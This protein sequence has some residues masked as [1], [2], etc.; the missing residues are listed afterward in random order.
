MGF[1]SI[2]TLALEEIRQKSRKRIYRTDPEAWLA[3][4]MG[5]RWWSK[6][7]E[8]AHD[9]VGTGNGQTFTLVKS[10]NGVGKTQLGADLMTW[11]V[12]AHDPLEVSVLATANVFTQISQNAFKYITDNYST[13]IDLGNPLP[14]R[15]VSDP[16]VRLDR[17]VGL[18][19]KD[20]IAGRRPADKNLLS[21]FQGTHDGFVMVLMDES[22]GLPEDLWIGAY[23]VTTNQHTAILA[24]GNPDE[25]GT[26]FHA[27]FTDVDRYSDWKRHTISHFDTPN[28][29]GEV[30]YPDDPE[31]ERKL[32]SLLPQVSTA[33]RLKRE[34]HPGVYRAKV[35]G[36]FPESSSSS[37]FPH[38]TIERAWNTEIVAADD[39][40]RILGVDLS[41]AGEDSTAFYLNQGG[42]IRRVNTYTKLDDDIEHA[43]R[44][45]DFA[46]RNGINRVQIDANGRGGGVYANLINPDLFPN[47]TYQLVGLLGGNSASDRTRWNNQRSEQYDSFREGMAKGLI[48]LDENDAELKEQLAFQT[49]NLNDR[50]QIRV[51]PKKEM[52]KSPDFLDAAIY[53]WFTPPELRGNSLPSGTVLAQE[54]SV[55][56]DYGYEATLRGA[57]RPL[58][59]R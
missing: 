12:S 53:A 15:I 5:R 34:A 57:G 28:F 40:L 54:R 29:T 51:T 7:A 14:G 56:E 19:P 44:I 42:N 21:S 35:L 6:Q 38:S 3:D 22:G 25:I 13:A 36:E 18:M 9:V 43:R 55:I 1:E 46:R 4:V 11:A 48:D 8:I 45:D 24:I 39:D 30:V 26:P 16:A 58:L 27:R 52:A 59:F 37:F 31:R 32:K 17:G 2:A 33:E 20:I 23:A 10:A 47:P 41:W 50:G 49:F